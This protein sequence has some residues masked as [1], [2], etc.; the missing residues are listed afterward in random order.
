MS[1]TGDHPSETAAPIAPAT[2]VNTSN[3]AINV[4]LPPHFVTSGDL[5]VQWK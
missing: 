5:A 2:A 4:P 3:F 1:D